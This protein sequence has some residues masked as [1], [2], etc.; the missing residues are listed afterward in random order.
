MSPKVDLM[1]RH[2]L[3]Y[4]YYINAEKNKSVSFQIVIVTGGAG[5]IGGAIVFRFLSDGAKVAILDLN[6]E[7][8]LAKIR[9]LSEAGVVTEDRVKC[10]KLDV[11]Y[12]RSLSSRNN[13]YPHSSLG[14]GPR[15]T[16]LWMI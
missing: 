15:V 14:L 10:W 7:A 5:G 9:E 6:Q 1:A 12:K 3:R 8:G 16:L 13:V 11:R 4:L 2:S